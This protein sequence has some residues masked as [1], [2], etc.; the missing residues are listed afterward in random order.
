[1]K[2][3]GKELEIFDTA[4]VFQ[5]YI[6]LL[7]KKFLT[8]GI[9]EVGAGIGSFTSHYCHLYKKIYVSDLDKKNYLK[10]KKKFSKKKN[11]KI[12]NEKIGKTKLKFNTII[13]LNVLEHIKEDKKEIKIALSK[14]NPGGH[15]IILVPA[16]QELYSKFD[17]AIGHCRRYKTSF[18]RS[19]TINNV[20]IK[21]L[22]YIDMV[23]YVLYF[24][25]KIFFKEEVYP[26]YLKVFLW[27]KLFSP[28]TIILDFLTGYKFGKN[29]LCVYEKKT[30]G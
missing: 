6:F 26:S 12:K 2:Y 8:N 15:L 10:L 1:M 3:P 5:K 18:F 30:K 16:H 29:V 24:F 22:V 13:Y 23:G 9:Y 21:K 17:K 11:I 14:L 28:I 20:K 27:D 4:K 7:I 25:N 19:A